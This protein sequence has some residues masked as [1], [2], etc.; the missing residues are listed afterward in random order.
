MASLT[1][2]VLLAAILLPVIH[3]ITPPL[4]FLAGTRPMP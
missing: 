2:V 1:A 4:R 3:V